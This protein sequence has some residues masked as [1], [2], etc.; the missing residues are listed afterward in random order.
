MFI[1]SQEKWQDLQTRM[2][3]TFWRLWLA[4]SAFVVPVKCKL[5]NI[6]KAKKLIFE[7]DNLNEVLIQ[8]WRMMSELKTTEKYILGGENN[9]SYQTPTPLCENLFNSFHLLSFWNKRFRI[10][11]QCIKSQWCTTGKPIFLISTT[12]ANHAQ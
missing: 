7:E 1:A 9:F 4:K 11:W 12:D 3:F 8:G 2:T 10:M 6:F 5:E